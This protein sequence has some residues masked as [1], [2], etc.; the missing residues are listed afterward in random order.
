VKSF[1]TKPMYP[2]VRYT[3][4][5]EEAALPETL[6]ESGAVPTIIYGSRVVGTFIA[7]TTIA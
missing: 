5:I 2:E 1:A 6:L 7:E 4:L 3:A